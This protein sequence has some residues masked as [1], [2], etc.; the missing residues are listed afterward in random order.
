MS[1]ANQNKNLYAALKKGASRRKQTKA[2]INKSIGLVKDSLLPKASKQKKASGG[3]NN[4]Y[5]KML[6]QAQTNFDKKLSKMSDD[7]NSKL[8]KNIGESSDKIKR[9]EEILKGRDK[10]FSDFAKRNNQLFSSVNNQIQNLAQQ[11]AASPAVP[12]TVEPDTSTEHR[13]VET[14]KDATTYDAEKD[15]K[16]AANYSDMVDEQIVE[17]PAGFKSI[18][19]PTFNS[20][21]QLAPGDSL[22]LGEYKL[23]FTNAFGVRSGDNAVSGISADE[24]SK[25]IDVR[26]YKDDKPVDM[27]VSIASGKIVKIGL[28][29]DGKYIST[30][31]GR[32]GGYYMYVQLDEDPNKI[33]KYVHL[34]K[35]VMEYKERLI[36]KHI[37]RGA[38]IVNTS[39]MSGTGTGPHVKISVGNYNPATGK[40]A[41]DYGKQE[42]DPTNLLLTGR[43]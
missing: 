2:E 1:A 20:N 37:P 34:P 17:Q 19:F 35:E 16:Q 28:H 24:T 9:L 23:K 33:V 29:G 31:E 8:Q 5:K 12:T 6:E 26:L 13:S 25:G 21:T 30:K 38:L 7:Y 3:D 10:G 39:G 40:S 43:L 4:S 27:P 32:Y 14:P 36:G 42:N 15:V 22:D 41:M 18:T 11:K